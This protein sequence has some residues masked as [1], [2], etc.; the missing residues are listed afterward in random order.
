MKVTIDRSECISCGVCWGECPDFF[1]ENPD[2]HWS[3]VVSAFRTAGDLS[4]GIAPSDL[5]QCVRQAAEGC[6]VQIIHAF[7]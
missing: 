4:Q 6:P 2:D 3:E 5:E 1:E 7:P